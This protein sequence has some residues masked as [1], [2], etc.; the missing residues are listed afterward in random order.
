MTNDFRIALTTISTLD[1]AKVLSNAI[2]EQKLA[3]CVNTLNIANSCYSWEGEINNSPEM[4]LSIKTTKHL[5]PA[6]I[7]FL[8]ANHPY[9][10]YF[11]SVLCPESINQTYFDW[12]LTNIKK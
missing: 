6:I 3:T 7:K 8:D 1:E 4:L 11:F 5:I 9:Q 10:T 12:L 2:I